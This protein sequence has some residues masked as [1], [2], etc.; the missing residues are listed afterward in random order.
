MLLAK[1]VNLPVPFPWKEVF[2]SLFGVCVWIP[3]FL[4]SERVKLTFVR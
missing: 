3:Y 4:K 2:R 1:S